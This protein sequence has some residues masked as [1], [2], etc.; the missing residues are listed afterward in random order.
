MLPNSSQQPAWISASTVGSAERER[1]FFR[2]VYSWMFGGML[3]TTVAAMWVAFSPA[4][5]QIVLANPIVYIVLCF[6]EIGVVFYASFALTRLTPAAAASLF[7]IYSLL[8]ASP[9]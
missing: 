4:M 9:A 7:L 1:A 5:Q 8:T 6:A 3:L 2:S